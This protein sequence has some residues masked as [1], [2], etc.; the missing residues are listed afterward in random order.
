MLVPDKKSVRQLEEDIEK[1][2]EKHVR[3]INDWMN[4]RIE[5]FDRSKTQVMAHES[6]VRK[7]D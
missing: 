2:R 3:S 1:L 5:S 6:C 4:T 7:A